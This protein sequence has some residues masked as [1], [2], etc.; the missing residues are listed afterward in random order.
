[1]D[2]I[3]QTRAI[4]KLRPNTAWTLDEHKGLCFNDEKI[5]KP[6]DAEIEQAAQEI[7]ASDAA[8]AQ[9]K[10][11]AKASAKAKLAALGLTADDIAALGL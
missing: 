9:A 7:L 2:L 4:H 11:D 10:A 5:T 1:M 6:T 8:K 3:L